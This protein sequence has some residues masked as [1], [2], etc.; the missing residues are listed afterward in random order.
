MHMHR[1]VHAIAQLN[2]SVE[3][4]ADNNPQLSDLNGSGSLE[5]DA[6]QVV[7]IWD[8][9]ATAPTEDLIMQYPENFNYRRSGIIRAIPIS[10][11]VAKNRNGGVGDTP[12]FLWDK[13]TNRFR[14]I[15]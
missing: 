2:R 1:P 6:S 9:W 10:L 11:H 13:A 8:A 15:Q 12:P 4:R 5:Q 3:H 14:M 7:F